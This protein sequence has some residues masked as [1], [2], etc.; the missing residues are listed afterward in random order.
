MKINVESI[1]FGS[2]AMPV[3][4][5]PCVIESRD[6]SLEMAAALNEIFS[7]LAVPFIFKS[8]F[9]KANR[10]AGDSFRG[11]GIDEGLQILSAVKNE[12]DVLILTDIHLSLIHI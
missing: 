2:H 9:D 3:I 4:A 12:T 11:P 8:S 1:V 7:R 10:T 5:G 6:H